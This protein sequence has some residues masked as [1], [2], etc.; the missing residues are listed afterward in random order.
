[1]TTGVYKIN[2]FNNRVGITREPV[3]FGTPSFIT[4][5]I[6]VVNSNEEN[7]WSPR[8]ASYQD[9]WTDTL[10]FEDDGSGGFDYS[11]SVTLP[12]RTGVSNTAL[13]E[14]VTDVWDNVNTLNITLDN[15]QESIMSLSETSILNGAN[16]LGI[17]TPSGE[18]EILQYTNAFLEV[19]GSYTLSRLLR[20][21]LGT[22]YYMGTPTPSGSTIVLL[23]NSDRLGR[24]EGTNE[25][26]GIQVNY[27]YGPN[28][29]AFSDD[30]YTEVSITPRG[31]ALRPYSP[32]HLQQVKESNGDITLSWI[33]RTRFDGDNWDNYPVPLHE[34]TEEYEIEISGGRSLDSSTPTVTYTESQQISDFGSS[35]ATVTWTVYQMS[36]LYGRGTPANG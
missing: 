14:G 19:D 22:E 1:M 10:I 32:V 34:E 21:K 2:S 4:L 17:L 12:A 6:P 36:A 20:G 23:D 33:R 7:L 18:W 5:E 11:T 35:Q 9:P 3:E 8:L 28:N 29:V 13:N 16:R 15:P 25:R 31:V 27:L 30:R 26:L 24:L